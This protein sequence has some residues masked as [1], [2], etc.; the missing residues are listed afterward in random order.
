MVALTYCKGLP[1]PA[2]ELNPLGKTQLEMF[3][4]EYS[5]IFHVCA[6]ETANYLLSGE[7]FN[8]S[9]WNTYLQQ[10]YGINKRHANGVIALS[11][12]AVDAAKANSQRHIKVLAA[13]I[14]SCA[15]WIKRA[16]RKLKNARKFYRRKNW[17]ASKTGC[18]LPIDCSIQYRQTN[19]QNLRFRLHHKKRKLH[20]Y[21]MQVEY[22]KAAPIRVTIPKGQV[23]V[24]GSKDEA[25]GNQ[26]CQWDGQ[27]IKF[28]VPYC[29]EEK[30]GK[31]VSSRIGD[32]PRKVNRLPVDGAKTWHFYR[33]D[34]RWCVA[35]QFTPAPVKQV[36]RSIQRGCIGIDLN[37]GSIGWSY[38]DPEG[39]LKHHGLLPIEMGLPRGKQDVAI[40]HVCF[41]L[42]G[43]ASAYQC[44][45]V[46]EQLDFSRKKTQLREKGRK[47]ARMLSG[48]AYSRFYELLRAILSNRGIDLVTVN[49][50][51]S[52][53]IGGVKYARMYGLASDEA[54]ALV[55]A[56]RGMRL[57]EKLPS[58]ITAYLEV[59]DRKHVWS[60]WNQ[61]NSKLKRSIHSRHLYYGISN[62][63]SLVNPQQGSVNA[64]GMNAEETYTAEFC[65]D[66]PKYG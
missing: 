44:P 7:K 53:L 22:L 12:G 64:L 59:N 24:V 11:K 49:P 60:H 18:Q 40:R 57:G 41:L 39:N 63:E 32:F 55:I 13:Q 65:L 9:E 2:E 37:P 45:I 35:V 54:A 46:C 62:W 20:H 14:K 31:Y 48:W 4:S 36:S 1:T 8:K 30:F 52:S 28:R 15:D 47:Y 27:T 5:A 23:Y 50:A 6:C 58:S 33:K 29:L 16:E 25:Y 34:G 38:V 43:M 56:R 3:L 61:L 10:A 19:W 42:L 51:Y 66:L 21:Q 17:Q 26:T